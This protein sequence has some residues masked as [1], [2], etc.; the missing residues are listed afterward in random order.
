MSGPD[1]L[2]IRGP[3]VLGISGLGSCGTRGPRGPSQQCSAA[4]PYIS[5]PCSPGTALWCAVVL[6]VAGGHTSLLAALDWHELN[7]TAALLLWVRR[8]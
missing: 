5:P 1:C 2:G 4:R 6:G 3:A 7:G 8:P